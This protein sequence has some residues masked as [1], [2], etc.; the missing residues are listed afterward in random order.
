MIH[1]SDNC[2]SSLLILTKHWT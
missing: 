1:I 2:F